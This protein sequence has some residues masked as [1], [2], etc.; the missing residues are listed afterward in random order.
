MLVKFPCPNKINR[1]IHNDGDRKTV[2]SLS[3]RYY[4]CHI[5]LVL[6]LIWIDCILTTFWK[7]WLCNKKQVQFSA[8]TSYCLDF[9]STLYFF[10]HLSDVSLSSL[11]LDVRYGC[12]AEAI[13]AACARNLTCK[14]PDKKLSPYHNH[15]YNKNRK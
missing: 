9:L 7:S 3:L 2:L 14:Q 12:P 1:F 4:K 5:R 15:I 8:S 11:F 10:A 13:V 6:Q